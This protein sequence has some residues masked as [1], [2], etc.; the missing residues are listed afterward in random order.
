MKL[1]LGSLEAAQVLYLQ[2]E[3]GHSLIRGASA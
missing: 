1:E 3:Q 2:V